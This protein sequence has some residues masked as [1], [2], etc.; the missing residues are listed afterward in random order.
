MKFDHILFPVDFS[1]HSPALNPEVEWLA[2]HFN[3]R[4]TLLNVFEVPATWYGGGD[5]PLM[6]AEDISALAEVEKQRLKDY[7]IQVPESRVQRVS[8]EGGAAWHI[9]KLVEEDDVDLVVMGTHGYGPVRRLLLGSVTMKVLH[10]V[11]CP[12]WTHS[13]FKQGDE[14][15]GFG[16]NRIVC[17][18]ELTEEATSLLRFVRGLAED[19]GA[20]VRL[21]HNVPGL[22]SRPAKYLDIDLHR[23]L[24]QAAVEEISKLQGEVGTDFP[25]T[26]ADGQIAQEVAEVARATNADLVVIGRGKTQERFG[27]LRTHAYEIIRQAPCPVLS[28]S[29]DQQERK[30]GPTIENLAGETVS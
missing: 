26:V 25:L 11:N 18:L 9:A 27:T 4:V 6:T 24:R 28:Y 3:S 5:A 2:A 23:Y 19:F 17:S 8:A 7:V 29:L 20:E 1:E 12:V 13:A 30:S 22:Q 14:A 10:D 15:Q 21:V 16:V